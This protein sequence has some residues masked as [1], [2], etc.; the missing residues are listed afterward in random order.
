MTTSVA[1]NIKS[2]ETP[3]RR[4][5][6]A[7]PLVR[8]VPSRRTSGS[9]S[10]HPTSSHPVAANATA[11]IAAAGRGDCRAWEQLIDE[12]SPMLRGIARSFR[13]APTDV[14]DVVQDT[15]IALHSNFSTLRNPDALPGWL[16]TT[17]RRRSLR[18]LQAAN[19]DQVAYGVSVDVADD[20]TPE[21]VLLAS[22]RRNVFAHAV[23]ALPMQQ[24]RVVTALAARPDLDY[25]QLAAML[26]MPIG[27]L[28]PTRARGL[29]TLARNEELRFVHTAGG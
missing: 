7:T 28:G 8:E 5:A 26:Q 1:N 4:R 14:D 27:S 9:T 11:M 3:R 13:L 12:F 19:R 24:R 20:Q 17:V 25:Q 15:W 23:G 16:A 22:E 18:L 6:F 29:A 21:K 2:T 10:T